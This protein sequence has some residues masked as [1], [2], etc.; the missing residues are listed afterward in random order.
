[1]ARAIVGHAERSGGYLRA[2][3]LA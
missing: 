3:D 1:M 2:E